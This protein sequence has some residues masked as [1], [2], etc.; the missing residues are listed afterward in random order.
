MQNSLSFIFFLPIRTTVNNN[1]SDFGF[2][3]W[4]DA[5]VSMMTV[6]ESDDTYTTLLKYIQNEYFVLNCSL[7]LLLALFSAVYIVSICKALLP[8]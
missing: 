1:I 4:Y 7:K 3:P 8:I 6:N 5:T 2:R